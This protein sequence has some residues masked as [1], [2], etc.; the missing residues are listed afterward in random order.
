MCLHVAIILVE[1]GSPANHGLQVSAISGFPSRT[2]YFRFFDF[3]KQGLTEQRRPRIFVLMLS[4]AVAQFIIEQ[5]L[6][7]G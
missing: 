6:N 1:N 3:V 5:E 4:L 2:Q 7:K